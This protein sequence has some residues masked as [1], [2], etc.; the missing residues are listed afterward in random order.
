MSNNFVIGG[1]WSVSLCASILDDLMSLGHVIG[2]NESATLVDVHE[3][4]TMDRLWFEHR[5]PVLREQRVQ[6]VWVR[7]KCD[8]NVPRKTGHD[9]WLTFKHF[10]KPMPSVTPGELHGGNS[11]TCG[12]NLAFQRMLEGDNLFLLGF[13]MCKGPDQQ[14]YWHKPYPWAS[15]EGATKPGHFK[16]WVN[17]LDG[18]ASFAKSRRFNVYNVSMRSRIELWPKIRPD[19]MMEMIG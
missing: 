18:F 4:I 2:V 15:P 17:D 10:S 16:Q 6:K 13:D 8:C 5:W 1:G 14:P 7:E 12:I 3:A 19:Q 9:N 11:G